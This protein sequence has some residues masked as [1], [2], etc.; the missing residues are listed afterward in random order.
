MLDAICQ[1]A[2]EAGDA[3]MQVYDGHKPMEVT[4]KV[5]DSPV[6]AADIA[7][8]GVIVRGLQALTPEIPVLSEEDPPGWEVRQTWGRY[9]LVDP[10][11]GTKEFI[12]RNG[13][14][15]VN[16]ALIENGKPV[17]G[18]VYAPVLQVMYSAAEGKAWK[19]EA[20]HHQQIQVRDARPPLVVVSRSHADDELKEYLQ[21]LGE[22][23][24]TAIGS[25]LKF[26]LVAEGKA[27]LYPRFGPTN[28]W[29]T[30]A[31]HA[32]AVAAGAH[33]HDWQGRTLDYTPRES[34]LNPG[35]RVSLY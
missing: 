8:H 24:T 15:T 35:F 2:R 32:V 30:A 25:S 27:Q 20:G 33:V 16:I 22:H 13:E 23:Q 31:G 10:L 1:L 7:A 6:T 34:F 5:D 3:I 26:C 4:S 19:E 28:V 29:D 18:V 17:L 21:H 11:D 14:F 9:W 12:K